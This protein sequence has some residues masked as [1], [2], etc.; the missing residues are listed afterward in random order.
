MK[1]IAE[2]KAK[3]SAKQKDAPN[4][5]EED[6]GDVFHMFDGVESDDQ[7]D[8]LY[9]PAEDDPFKEFDFTVPS[10]QSADHQEPEALNLDTLVDDFVS[11][12]DPSEEHNEESS[13]I[14]DENPQ[15]VDPFFA[16]P[17]ESSPLPAESSPLPA[18]SSPLPDVSS[19]L[20]SNET[21]DELTPTSEEVTERSLEDNENP[22]IDYLDELYN[23]AVSQTIHFYHCLLGYIASVNCLMCEHSLKQSHLVTEQTRTN[24]TFPWPRW[25]SPQAGWAS[26]REWGTPWAR[27]R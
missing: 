13:V 22:V 15:Q 2:K 8:L 17:V 21:N 18:E 3:K 14:P 24:I 10:V 5:Q 27:G 25:S 23:Y 26:K 11:Q 16:E 1:E 4:V 19:P 9:F 20:Q 12:I 6:N 7:E